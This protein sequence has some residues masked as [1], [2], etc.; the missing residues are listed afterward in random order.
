MVK[1]NFDMLSNQCFKNYLEYLIGKVYKI[2]PIQENEPN[3]LIPYLESL[4][5]ELIGNQSLIENIR[6]DA[7]FM[8]LVGTIQY[9]ISNKC[10]HK[11]YRREVFKCI[12][13]I[14][15]LQNKYFPKVGES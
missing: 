6:Y 14:K 11:I 4:Q 12:D 15:L 10:E 1:V 7:K 3:T 9:L 8:E 13:I 2:L 5:V